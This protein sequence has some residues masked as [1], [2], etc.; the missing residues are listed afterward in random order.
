MSLALDQHQAGK[1]EVADALYSRI[2]EVDPENIDCLHYLGVV[3]LQ[4][5]KWDMALEL[6]GKARAKRPD[7][8]RILSHYAATLN[9]LERFAEAEVDARRAVALCPDLGTAHINLGNALRNQVKLADAAATYATALRYEP[10]RSDR[11]YLPKTASILTLKD[12]CG[13][14][15]SPSAGGEVMVQVSRPYSQ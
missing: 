7:D 12:Y 2:L 1:L 9:G 4:V 8:P 10:D 5:E 6:I 13:R 11:D 14:E 15:C 3:A